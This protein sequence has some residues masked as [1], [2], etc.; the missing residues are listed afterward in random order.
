MI[1]PSTDIQLLKTAFTIS[2]KN[3]L[4]FES[5]GSQIA[6]FDNLPRYEEDNATYQRKDGVIRF[7]ALIDDILEF[8]YV[9]YKNENYSDKWFYAFILDMQYV[10]DNMTLIK[11]Q[12]DVF[13]TWQ[14]D[15]QFKPSFVEREMCNVSDDT[16]QKNLDLEDLETGEYIENRSA[17]IDGL[18]PVF[19]IAYARDPHTDE[20][21]SNPSDQN[22][23][24]INSFPSGL[25]YCF[26]ASEMVLYQIQQ[27]SN[28]SLDESIIAVFTVPVT[29]IYGIIPNMTDEQIDNS[30]ENQN[31]RFWANISLNDCHGREL[32]LNG[33]HT[34]IDSYVP[35]NK[36]LLHY[37]YQYLGF[38]PSNGTSKIFRYED[39]DGNPSFS[40]RSEVNPNPSVMFI[41]KKYKGSSGVNVAESVSL[42]GYPNIAWKTDTYN[43]WIGQ[44]QALIKLDMGQEREK[45]INQQS[46][47]LGSA[48]GGFVGV[49]GSAV[50]GDVGGVLEGAVDMSKASMQMEESRINHEYNVNRQMATIEAHKLLPNKGTIGSNN[51]TLIQYN[52]FDNDIF[53]N[54]SIKRE[55]AEKLDSYFDM[56]GYKTNRVKIPN[57]KNRPNW[58]YVK[59]INATIRAD[60]PQSDLQSLRAIFDNGV[61]LWHRPETFCDYSANN[62]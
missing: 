20:L 35:R 62:R 12:T 54:Y 59:T 1:A 32:S 25:W 6:Y 10:N 40:M 22:G 29:A 44:N 5:R 36:K 28:K 43:A 13:Q 34:S 2:N 45:Y 15:F 48:V 17:E 38:N 19:V 27:I 47:L 41:P 14:F 50:Q 42:A 18:R 30:L 37:P 53:K 61:T 23:T 39:F 9:R 46:Q 24:L 7:P 3:Q 58:N 8:N 55:F 51:T 4:T 49:V 26:C 60:I 11:I 21:T 31:L 16:F 57:L 56:Y 33:H 52:L